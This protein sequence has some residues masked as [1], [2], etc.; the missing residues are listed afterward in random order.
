MLDSRAGMSESAGKRTTSHILY[1]RLATTESSLFSPDAEH[2]PV[3]ADHEP[4]SH[5]TLYAP[6]NPFLQVA[7]HFAPARLPL[8]FL[9]GQALLGGAN[10]SAPVQP[11]EMSM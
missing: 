2:A 9:R 8:H 7:T 3:I 5:V 6:A 1:V 10:G 11:E 4:L